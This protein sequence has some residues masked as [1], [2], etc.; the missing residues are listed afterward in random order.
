MRNIV[1]RAPSAY[2]GRGAQKDY[3][4][5]DEKA[6]QPRVPHYVA[7]GKGAAYYFLN[8]VFKIAE[9]FGGVPYRRTPTR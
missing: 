9:S 1:L 4:V 7:D 8:T 3:Y 5:A 6:R 2:G